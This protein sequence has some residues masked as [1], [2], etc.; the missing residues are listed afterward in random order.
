VTDKEKLALNWLSNN[1]AGTVARSFDFAQ[2]DKAITE[3]YISLFLE[4]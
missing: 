2:D 1:D 3:V 4:N